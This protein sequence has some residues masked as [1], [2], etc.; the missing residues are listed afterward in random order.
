MKNFQRLISKKNR[1][2]KANLNLNKVNQRVDVSVE[3]FDWTNVDMSENEFFSKD[4]H[5]N[6]D[7]ILA[8]GMWCRMRHFFY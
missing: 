5:K 6:I 4:K 7:L 1:Q 2:I 3:K 8:S